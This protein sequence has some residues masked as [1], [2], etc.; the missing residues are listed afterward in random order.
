METIYIDTLFLI[1]LII[2]YFILLCTAKVSG[3]RIRRGW[4]FLGALIGAIY[5]CL[6]VWPGLPY[7]HQPVMKLAFGGLIC[8][9]AFHQES[10][11][12]RCC[13]FFFLL[14]AGFAG[15][16]WA[17][18][19]FGGYGPVGS[20]LYLPLNGKVLM[21]SFAVAY[22]LLSVFLRRFDETARETLLEVEVELHGRKTAFLALRDTGNTLYDPMTN[23]RVLVCEQRCAAALFGPDTPLLDARQPAE[24]FRKLSDLPTWKGALRLVPF[25]S[26]GGAGLLL[27]FHP[28]KLTIDGTLEQDTLIAVTD[29]VLSAYN[30]YQAI[31]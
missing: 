31:Y 5:A 21:L 27:A 8:L 4:C 17:V 3:A 11:F 24:S 29:T 14:S 10:Q 18:S 30:R 28:E 23:C 20:V 7:F 6:C 9:A 16:L 25:Q 2:D 1:N 12:L 13:L 19:L 22:V 26:V 15:I